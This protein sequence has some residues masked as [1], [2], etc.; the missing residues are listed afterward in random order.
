M[1]ADVLHLLDH[2]IEADD[3]DGT[4]W[5]SQV[6]LVGT[7]MG[8]MISLEVALAAPS[9][10]ASLSLVSA[11]AGGFGMVPPARGVV[12]VAR[13]FALC[14]NEVDII[15]AAC[16]IKYPDVLLDVPGPSHTDT[17]CVG[18]GGSLWRGQ[19]PDSAEMAWAAAYDAR[20]CLGLKILRRMRKTG[21]R[22]KVVAF[23]V[24]DILP[25][26]GAV[27]SHFVSDARLRHLR[28]CG[29]PVLV[30]Y[31]EQDAIVPA[32]NARV[33]I[34]LLGAHQV[35]H[36]EAGH[37]VNEQC[38][39]SVNAALLAHFDSSSLQ[40]RAQQET[41]M[42]GQGQLATRIR[43][44]AAPDGHQY[45]YQCLLLFVAMALRQLGV[46][47]S[48]LGAALLGL[49]QRWLDARDRTGGGRGLLPFI[50]DRIGG[51]RGQD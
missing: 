49:A 45:R 3:N 41:E 8:G 11:H 32:H 24:G 26:L 17:A 38:R 37:C 40:A 47:R 29:L 39:A 1:A 51:G 2:C 36:P 43:R 50:W 42:Q 9:R 21:E 12:A 6:H 48:V 31:G 14:R 19:D 44:G 33:L 34:R 15:N 7:S 22:N 10:F 16:Q 20:S 23:N 18:D 46:R 35:S 27:G 4:G 25:Q 28:A 5:A 13:T 30:V